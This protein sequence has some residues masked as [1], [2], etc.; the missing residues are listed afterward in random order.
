MPAG[1]APGKSTWDVTPQPYRPGTSDFNGAV[2]EN[3]GAN[4]PNPATMPTAE[5]FNTMSLLLVSLGK[6]VPNAVISVAGGAT[7]AITGFAAAPSA[8]VLST[9][10]VTRLGA[11]N[12]KVT[13]PAGTFPAAA[14]QP[15]VSLNNI[16][17][18]GS[19]YFVSAQN[20]TN[21]VQVYTI[22]NSTAD[23]IPFTITVY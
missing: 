3:S 5:L 6:V 2:L 13:W 22:I 10:T 11:G 1:T 20:I 15:T 19:N 12:V 21:G 18:A 16:V 23:D 17:A 14:T 7:P 4:P 8:V 9:F